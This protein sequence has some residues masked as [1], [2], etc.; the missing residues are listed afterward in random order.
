MAGNGGINGHL[1]HFID[2]NPKNGMQV[3]FPV[4]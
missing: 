4:I 2:A 1:Q 3:W